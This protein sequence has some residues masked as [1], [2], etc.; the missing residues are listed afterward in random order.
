M[1]CTVKLIFWDGAPATGVLLAVLCDETPRL[2]AHAALRNHTR[3]TRPC[4]PAES[5]LTVAPSLTIR[6]ET[7]LGTALNHVNFHVRTKTL[8]QMRL[9]ILLIKSA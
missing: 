4:T 6:M 3:S 7:I 5:Y 2:C 1:P 8:F 9:F